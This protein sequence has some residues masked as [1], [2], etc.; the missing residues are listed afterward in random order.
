MRARSKIASEMVTCAECKRLRDEFTRLGIEDTA[1]KDELR[2]TAKTSPDYGLRLDEAK[3][4]ASRSYH[5]FQLLQQ[6]EKD[7]RHGLFSNRP[8]PN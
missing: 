6:H 8:P 1:A 2:Q 7:Y 5:A 3:K 4:A